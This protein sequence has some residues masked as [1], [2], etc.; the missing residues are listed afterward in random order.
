MEELFRAVAHMNE[1]GLE[2][3]KFGVLIGER[4]MAALLD[5]ALGM[6]DFVAELPV[7]DAA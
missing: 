1:E 7:H 4:G 6:F 3:L 2:D 5:E